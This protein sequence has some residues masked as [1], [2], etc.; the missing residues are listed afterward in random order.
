MKTGSLVSVSP[1][2]TDPV[3][4]TSND[5][6]IEMTYSQEWLDGTLD[7]PSALNNVQFL[8]EFAPIDGLLT[9]AS[10]RSQR[11]G[12]EQATGLTGATEYRTGHA[13]NM[14][15][16]STFLQTVMYQRYLSS[17][18]IDFEEV[19]RWYFEEHIPAE[20]GIKG[21]QF[22]PSSPLGNYLERCRNL[23]AE[24]ESI[25]TQYTLY[26][27]DGEIDDDLAT[28][29]SDQV[30]YKNVPSVLDAKYAY[31]NINPDVQFVLYALFSDQSR[32]VGR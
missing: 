12:F 11:S 29:G 2:Q 10:F 20:Y 18:D 28:A 13:F 32:L 4:A 15:D 26:V 23:F 3:V 22:N 8:F 1:T 21:F 31:S 5:L 24:M 17:K 27:D 6:D 19:I 7:Y 14:R 9:L 30:K 25:L 16:Q